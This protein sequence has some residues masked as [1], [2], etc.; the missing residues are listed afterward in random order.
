M[1]ALSSGL[2]SPPLSRSNAASP[3]PKFD[4]GLL[5]TYMK[6]LLSTTLQ[7]KAWAEVKDRE[8]LKAITKELGERV[9]ERMVEIQPRGFKYVVLIQIHENLGQGGRADIVCHWEDNDVVAQ[10]MYANDS[11][12]AVCIGLAVA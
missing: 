2:R 5:K 7:S 11:L 1:D 6:M 3:R 9:K 4:G 8:K 10:E 12:I